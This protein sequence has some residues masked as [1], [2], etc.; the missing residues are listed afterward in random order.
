MKKTIIIFCLG[1]IPVLKAQVGIGTANPD[2]SAALEVSSTTKGFLPPR[3][4]AAQ[5]DAIINPPQGLMLYCTDCGT[6]GQLQ[7]YN[8]FEFK[9]SIGE[10][11]AFSFRTQLGA[12]IYGEGANDRSG[13]SVDLSSDGTKLA[14]GARYNDGSGSNS[15][16]VRVFGYNNN[17]WAQ[18]GG[19]ID[20]EAADDNSGYAISLNSN[21]TKLAVGAYGNDGNGNRSGHVRVYEYSNSTWTQ[22]G[23][24]ID[25]ETADD[26]SGVSVDLSN[27]GQIVAI[28]AFYNDGNGTKSGHVRVYKNI[29]GIWTQ[30]GT[31]I[32]GSS[33]GEEAGTSISLS[34]DGLTLAIGAPRN[35]DNGSSSGEVRIFSFNGSN[36]VQK[37][38]D[39]NGDASGDYFG[40]SVSLSNSGST[41]AIGAY[42]NDDSGTDAG[43]VKIFEFIGGSWVQR[44]SKIL[45]EMS[46]D[47][48][49]RSISLSGDGNLLAIGAYSNDGEANNAGHTR[50]FKY[51]NSSWSQVDIDI[52][53]ENLGDNSGICVALSSDGSTL[54]I[55]AEYCDGLNNLN[56]IGQVKVF[57]KR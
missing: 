4:T 8:G 48:S 56:D 25:G 32:D 23:S 34:G 57:L 42:G 49:G 26:L 11:R 6:Y 27:N 31:D 17:L 16:H 19:D 37:G 50:I 55:G 1:I 35:D 5:R 45:G 38:Q 13:I 7:V 40:I 2:A 53:G 20:G 30:M 21:G 29:S 47:Y 54:A 14:V 15:G 39:L 3:M 24:D 9:N 46:G 12:S 43:Q 33:A 28:G 51:I 41:V 52:D 22:L 44:G 10:E 36:W 18:I